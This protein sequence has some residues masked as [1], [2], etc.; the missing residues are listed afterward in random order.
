MIARVLP[1][2]EWPRLVGTEAETAW[3][4]FDPENTRVLVVEDGGEIVATWTVMRVV[5]V[6]CLWAK[7]SHRGMFGVAKRLLKA[8]RETASAWGARNVVTGSVS[9][10]VTDLIRRFGGMPMPC[11]SFVLPVEIVNTRAIRRRYAESLA[12]QEEPC[13]S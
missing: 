10:H 2:E 4:H 5:H 12:K 3:P 11:E 13:L 7:P 6:E 8:M 9:P 1:P